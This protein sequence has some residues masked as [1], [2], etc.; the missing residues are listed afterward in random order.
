MAG[1]KPPVACSLP[2]FSTSVL[3]HSRYSPNSQI[4][5]SWSSSLE[6]KAQER[7][8]SYRED[9]ASNAPSL[10]NITCHCCCAKNRSRPHADFDQTCKRSTHII[11]DYD[12]YW[13]IRNDSINFTSSRPL[14]VLCRQTRT[15]VRPPHNAGTAPPPS[16]ATR[17][18]L[19]L[20]PPFP[21]LHHAI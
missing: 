3:W 14:L 1:F 12:T 18:A 11:F 7:H 6:E 9:L 17:P 5:S 4:S 10:V 8:R 21:F 2:P 15:C 16:P 13:D 20:L 19:I